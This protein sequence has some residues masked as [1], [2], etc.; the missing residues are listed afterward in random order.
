M[1]VKIRFDY[2]LEKSRSNSERH[3]IDFEEAQKLWDGTHVIIPAKHVSGERRFAV[4]GLIRGKVYMAICTKRSG[5]VR[6]ISCHRAGKKW[7]EIYYERL[8]KEET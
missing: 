7:E 4:L 2:D 6:I 1:L 3:K 8:K 5:A